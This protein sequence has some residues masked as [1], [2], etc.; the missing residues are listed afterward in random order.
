[1]RV[2]AWRRVPLSLLPLLLSFAEAAG[3][4][5]LP[6]GRLWCTFV[7]TVC[8]DHFAEGQHFRYGACALDGNLSSSTSRN[9]FGPQ[10]V[11]LVNLHGEAYRRGQRLELSVRAATLHDMPRHDA[12]HRRT[13]AEG[14]WSSAPI[15]GDHASSAPHEPMWHHWRTGLFVE[16]VV[17]AE[18]AVQ[19]RRRLH[20][21]ALQN[22]PGAPR[23]RTLLTLCM[24]YVQ[25][26]HRCDELADEAWERGVTQTH[27]D[28]SYQRLD[29][30]WDRPNSRFYVVQ[31]DTNATQL[32]LSTISCETFMAVETPEALDIARTLYTDANLDYSHLEYIVPPN[33]VNCEWA[34]L[35]TLGTYNPAGD[36][37]VP[38][39]ADGTTWNKGPGMSVRAHE[40]GHKQGTG[41]IELGT[42][43]RP[44]A[45]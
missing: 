5:A 6:S 33:L 19:Q 43:C 14:E 17:G 32:D 40:L 12:H 45:R 25:S 42:L 18:S 8:E 28:A 38:I 29:P 3:R 24:S 26:T 44:H 10:V 41:K 13:S 34:G 11:H 36:G 23:R 20:V 31:M 39:P 4:A 1:M 37:S 22:T 7:A 27:T 30:P 15:A 2:I 21:D 16:D 35:G 9:A